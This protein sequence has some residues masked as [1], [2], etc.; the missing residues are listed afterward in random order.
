MKQFAK[1]NDFKIRVARL[2][3]DYDVFFVDLWR[4][5]V[6]LTGGNVFDDPDFH[7]HVYID[8]DKGG[9]MEMADSLVDGMKEAMSQIPGVTV[10]QRK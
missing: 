7:V 9:T 10:K 1:T 2:R 6:M 8:P 5:S 4:T 3:P